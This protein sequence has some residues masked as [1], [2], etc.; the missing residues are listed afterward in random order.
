MM[1]ELA[2]TLVQLSGPD[3]VQGYIPQDVIS[4]ERPGEGPG[5]PGSGTGEGV[6]QSWLDRLMKSKPSKNGAEKEPKIQN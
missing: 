6:R 2:K 5:D 1:G 3:A 4:L